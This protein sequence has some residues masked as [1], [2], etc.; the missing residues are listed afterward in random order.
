MSGILCGPRADCADLNVNRWHCM[1][2]HD[3]AP[4][5]VCPLRVCER[6]GANRTAAPESQPSSSEEDTT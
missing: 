1:R 6:R 4:A 3:G 5:G 2:G